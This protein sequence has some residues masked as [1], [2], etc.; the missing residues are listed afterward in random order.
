M[1]K[2]RWSR[3]EIRK[4]LSKARAILRQPDTFTREYVLWAWEALLLLGTAEEKQK[5]ELALSAVNSA[6]RMNAFELMNIRGTVSAAVREA[7]KIL[8]DEKSWAIDDILWAREFLQYFENAKRNEE[9]HES[10][11]N[12][13]DE[14]AKSV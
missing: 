5:A 13:D 3:A 8:G 4:Y 11:C 14:I 10:T 9:P 12:S 6:L 7:R 2:S 1:S